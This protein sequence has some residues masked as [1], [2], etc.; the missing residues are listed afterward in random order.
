MTWEKGPHFLSANLEMGT[1]P[2]SR[3]ASFAMD[4]PTQNLSILNS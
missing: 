4:V 3:E 2:V 1:V